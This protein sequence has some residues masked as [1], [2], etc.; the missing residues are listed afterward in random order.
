M[1]RIDWEAGGREH[2]RGSVGQVGVDVRAREQW[3]AERAKKGKK[4]GWTFGV[5]S[6]FQAKC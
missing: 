1:H 5:C 4:A 3:P 6:S 2:S